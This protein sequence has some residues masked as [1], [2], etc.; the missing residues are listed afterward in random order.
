MILR[1]SETTPDVRVLTLNGSSPDVLPQFVDAAHKHVMLYSCF[2]PGLILN[3]RRESK[4]RCRSV[5]GQDLA[6]GPPMSDPL[7]TARRS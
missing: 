7:R 4:P 3:V 5:D 6:T 1:D 2:L